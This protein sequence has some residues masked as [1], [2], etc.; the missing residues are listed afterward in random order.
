M[1]VF[2]MRVFRWMIVILTV[3]AAPG[4]AIKAWRLMN[5]GT[6]QQASEYAIRVGFCV[7]LITLG[8]KFTSRSKED[9]DDPS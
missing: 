9:W 7:F 1:R 4:V 8:L 2:W 5:H 6:E 3:A